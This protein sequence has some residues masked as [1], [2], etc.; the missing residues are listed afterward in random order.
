MAPLEGA[1]P[2]PSRNWNF[3]K[4]RDGGGQA[5]AQLAVE[6]D[7]EFPPEA[8]FLGKLKRFWDLRVLAWLSLEPKTT[9]LGKSPE[10]PGKVHK[11]GCVSFMGKVRARLLPQS[12]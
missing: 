9:S 2:A 1:D 5:L 12:R 3:P 6:T 8:V 7:V 10:T 11:M 4:V